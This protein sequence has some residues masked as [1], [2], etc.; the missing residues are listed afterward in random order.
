LPLT[1]QSFRDSGADVCG[2]A[3]D[4]SLASRSLAYYLK[5]TEE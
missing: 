3:A 5:T 4:E 2:A 1:T